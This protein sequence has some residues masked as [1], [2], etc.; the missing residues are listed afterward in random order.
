MFKWL[1]KSKKI[2]RWEFN[3]NDYVVSESEIEM[4]NK[5]DR[6][7]LCLK[8]RDEIKQQESLKR[9]RSFFRVF[10]NDNEYGDDHE[11]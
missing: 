1:K 2:N 5:R 7:M 11:C 9:L 3:I 10:R 8:A 4:K 6:Y